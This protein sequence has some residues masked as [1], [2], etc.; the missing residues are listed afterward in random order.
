MSYYLFCCY[1]WSRKTRSTEL[2]SVSP[3]GGGG[4]CQTIS[5]KSKKS[6]IAGNVFAVCHSHFI[7]FC[8][9]GA[10]IAHP[11]SFLCCVFL[12]CLSSFC[13]LCITLFIS[14]L[15]ILEFSLTIPPGTT[16]TCSSIPP[17][18][19]NIKKDMKFSAHDTFLE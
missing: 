12:F 13:V 16:L 14:G 1:W 6:S 9:S 17:S 15:S 3:V 8:F 18:N 4:C 7:C 2:T 19:S 5:S 10:Y 11:F